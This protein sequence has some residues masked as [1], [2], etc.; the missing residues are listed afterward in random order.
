MVADTRAVAAAAIAE[1]LDPLAALDSAIA[2]V[3]ERL[4][5]A[6]P[7]LAMLFAGPAYAHAY[8]ELVAAAHTRLGA[9]ILI[10]C[11]GEGVIGPRREVERMPALS[12]LAHVLPDAQFRVAHLAP[13]VAGGPADAL[14][15]A[16]AAIAGPGV[17]GWLVLADP[18]TT[19]VE[20]LAA[21]L[22]AAAPNVPVLGGMASSLGQGTH[23]FLNGVAYD[24]GAVVLAVTS[25]Y[26]VRPVVSQGASPIGK[27]WTIT[28]VRENLVETI[29]GRPAQE[30]LAETL[31]GLPPATLERVRTGLLVGLAM[32]EYRDD[33]SR[34]DFLI[35]NLLG[36][37]PETGAL[38]VS[39]Y[40][41]A[42]QTIQFQFRDAQ[43][44]SEDLRLRL[45]DA[46]A[47]SAGSEPIAALLCTCN[48]RGS[49][50]F[51]PGDHDAVAL[52]EAFPGLPVGGLFCAG[53]IGTVGNRTFLH[54][55]TASIGLLVR[56]D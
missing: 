25:P 39:A 1:G 47:A 55:F 8:G 20:T 5:D 48:G 49:R 34:G 44:A 4:G 29:A 9:R 32:N 18:H 40:P 2:A 21:S 50:M 14:R 45:A 51:G 43:A 38:A 24:E 11:S 31:H 56:E 22:E 3:R 7:E 6:R 16:I 17:R 12:L 13:G 28:G 36:Y 27:T 42:G 53:E 23:V 37:D 41:R 52:D 26:A 30:V 54:G 19:D 10:G 46:R 35:R 15:E 33:F